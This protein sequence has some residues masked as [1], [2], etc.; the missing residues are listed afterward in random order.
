MRAWRFPWPADEP[1]PT[2]HRPVGCSHCAKTG[3]KGR[4]AL[5]EVMNVSEQI[6]RMAVERAS[7]DEIARVAREEGMLGL[8]EDG[9][10]KVVQGLTSIEEIFRVVV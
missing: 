9:L 7:G 4:L 10:E 8:R 1:L 3:Y 6:E 2:L 5:Q